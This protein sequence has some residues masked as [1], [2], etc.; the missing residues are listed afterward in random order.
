MRRNSHVSGKAVGRLFVGTA[1]LVA[2]GLV[3]PAH[4]QQPPPSVSLSWGI[5]TTDAN[6]RDVVRLVRAYLAQPDSSARSRGLWSTATELDRRAGD[7]TMPMGTY[8]GFPAT[9]VG[10][11]SNG[12]GD[13]VYTVKVLHGDAD[14]TRLR[15]NPLALQRLYAVRE[16]GAQFGFRLAGA[17]PRLT[18]H[19]ERRSRGGMTFWY[20]PGQQPNSDRVIRAERFV[21]SVAKLFGVPAP[22]H[23]DVYVTAAMDE[24]ER[25]LG[26]DFYVRMGSS[27]GG[28]T[29]PFNIVLAGDPAV[30]EEYLHE[31]VHAVLYSTFPSNN[32][33][34]GEGVATWLGGSQ[35]RTPRQLYAHLRRYQE[36]HPRLTFADLLRGPP[37]EGARAWT[38]AHRATGALV[39]DTI[40]RRQGVP[41]LRSFAL[42]KRDPDIL[43]AALPARLGLAPSD[44]AALDR[45]WRSEAERAAKT[46]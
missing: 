4:A 23:L 45:W 32:G 18:S 2:P 24:A 19:W 9:I 31:L 40:Y 6:V 35:G 33:L 34:F 10:I 29:L 22:G 44:P 41:G 46:R 8:Q 38:D 39:V 16:P 43:L 5:D 3:S 14:S 26:L 25:A 21:D 27:R 17:L 11:N 12:P 28:S 15:I 20:A 37:D 42:L 1:L 36:A 30:G 7:L 13:S